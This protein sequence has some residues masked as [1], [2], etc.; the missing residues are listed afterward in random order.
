MRQHLKH[1]GAFSMTLK[2]EVDY[3]IISLETNENKI[4]HAIVIVGFLLSLSFSNLSH[5]SKTWTHWYIS[6]SATWNTPVREKT[7]YCHILLHCH[8]QTNHVTSSAI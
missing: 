6:Q 2:G 8:T 1:A 5:D 7:T 4:I 3:Y